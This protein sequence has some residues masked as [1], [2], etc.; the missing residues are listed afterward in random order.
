MKGQGMT[1]IEGASTLGVLTGILASLVAVIA[2]II[3]GARD[4][5]E[6]AYHAHQVNQ[7][8]NNR[9]HDHPNLYD[10][11]SF[12]R[13]EVAELVAAQRDFTKR[14]WQSLPDDIGTASRLT[15]TIRAL[16]GHDARIDEKLNDILLELREHVAWEMNEKYREH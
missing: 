9:P 10:Q 7:A 16:Q 14:G 8:V 13:E 6:A 3:R 11:V 5:K 15:E 12:I 2:L 1:P 4:A